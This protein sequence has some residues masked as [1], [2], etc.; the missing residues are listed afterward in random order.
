MSTLTQKS[1]EELISLCLAG[2]DLGYSGLYTKYAKRTY[3]SIQRI[4]S[5][6]GEAE[7][8]LQDTFVTVFKELEKLSSL[9]SF[10]AWVKR[11]AINKSISHF[12][13]RKIDWMEFPSTDVAA[14]AEYDPEE[15]EIF[16]AKVED[17]RRCISELPDGY[18]TI[19]N[20]YLFEQIPQEEIANMLSLT[21]TTVRTQYHRAKKKIL[22][23]LKD[24]VYE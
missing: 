3:N 16:E 5:H 14:E 4:V 2:S 6:T 1:D 17:V 23:V 19:V 18:R 15:N 22:S 12:R 24:K 10:E 13:K 9:N 20:L 11:V 8:L 21:H 7:D